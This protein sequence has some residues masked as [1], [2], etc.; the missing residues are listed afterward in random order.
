LRHFGRAVEVSAVDAGCFEDAVESTGARRQ[1]VILGKPV[2]SRPKEARRRPVAA[3]E[4]IC[5]V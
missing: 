4:N 1:P 5:D 3:F 2:F